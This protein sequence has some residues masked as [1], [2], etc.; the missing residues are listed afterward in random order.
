[1]GLHGMLQGYLYL[2]VPQTM[3]MFIIISAQVAV[4]GVLGCGWWL[5]GVTVER[6]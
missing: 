1:M 3:D 4:S 2:F 6:M 5:I